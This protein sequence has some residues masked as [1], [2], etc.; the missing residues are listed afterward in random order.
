MSV[1]RIAPLLLLAACASSE[2]QSAESLVPRQV[3]F[4]DSCNPA[5]VEEFQLW[6]RSREESLRSPDSYLGLSALLWLRE[7]SNL[8]GSAAGSDLALA[9]GRAPAR[10]GVIDLSDGRALLRVEPGVRVT[11]EGQAV[12]ELM[13]QTDTD[14]AATRV[15]LGD[16][17]LHL[18]ERGGRVG[19][20][21][22]DPQSPILA[23]YESTPT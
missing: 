10:V 5:Y 16:L 14:G 8:L 4:D 6:R 13:L 17:E 1:M 12:A 7:G 3:A 15:Y 9:Q 11:F 22:R 20:R 23:A 19:M 2:R 18:I 21:V